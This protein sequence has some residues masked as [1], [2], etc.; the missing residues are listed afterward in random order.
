M[1]NQPIHEDIFDVILK[2]IW[3]KGRFHIFIVIHSFIL[4]NKIKLLYS[5]TRTYV[6]ILTE[7][8]HMAVIRLN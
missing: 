5:W 2:G 6:L 4:V 7:Q 8:L 1:D 3:G